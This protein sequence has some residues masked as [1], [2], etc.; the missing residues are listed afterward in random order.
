MAKSSLCSIPDCGKSAIAR[1]FCRRH[2]QQGWPYGGP[3]LNRTHGYASGKKKHPLYLVWRGMRSR[4]ENPNVKGYSDYGGRGITV[5]ERWRIGEDEKSGFE[6]FFEDMG[7]K[8]SPSHSVERVRNDGPYSPQNCIWATRKAQAINR[9]NVHRI[10]IDGRT[11]T[12]KEAAAHYGH[13]ASL[14]KCR[15]LR[16]WSL[17][18]ALTKPRDARG[19]HNHIRS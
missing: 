10:D 8:P 7:P 17:H 9:R 11:M 13:T 19:A 15:L 2:Y 18:D 1:G 12:L 16:G 4:C 14:V 6:C 3:P 5:C